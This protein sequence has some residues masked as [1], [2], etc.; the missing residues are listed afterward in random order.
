M[1]IVEH[2]SLLHAREFSGYIPR[3]GIA[4]SSGNYKVSVRQRTLSI[5]QN[6]KQQI[7][8]RYLPTLHPTEG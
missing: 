1:N 8:K 3:S 6:N 4:G 2:V 7:G 5:G